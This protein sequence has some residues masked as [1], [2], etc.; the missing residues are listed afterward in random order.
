MLSIS[1]EIA[2]EA[3]QSAIDLFLV[4]F[5]VC[6][7]RWADL[8]ERLAG[9]PAPTAADPQHAPEGNEDQGASSQTCEQQD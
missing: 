9:R 8:A 4:H 1:S 5:P 7:R 2:T 3:K 6:R